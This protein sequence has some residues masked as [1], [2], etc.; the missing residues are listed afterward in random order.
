M[1][2][3]AAAIHLLLAQHLMVIWVLKY[4][5]LATLFIPENKKY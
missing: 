1:S 2:H 5:Q 4:V 3:A